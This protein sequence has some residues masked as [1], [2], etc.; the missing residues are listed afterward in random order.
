MEKGIYSAID[1]NINRALEGLRVCEDLFRFIKRNGKISERLKEIRHSIIEE[2]KI[3]P[4]ELLLHERDVEND[5]IKFT[6]LESET[7]RGSLY[8]LL[9]KNLHRAMEALRSIEEFYKLIHPGEKKNPFQGIR[10]SLYSLEK[11][12]CLP[13]LRFEKE[14][15]FE[16]SLYAILDSSFVEDNKYIETASRL[17]TG[18]ASIIQLRMKDSDLKE[19][20]SR[21]REVSS[22]CKEKNVLFIV[23]DYPEIAVLSDADGV[24]LGQDDLPVHEARKI[25]PPDMLIGVSTRSV[26]QATE[27][28]RDMPDYIAIGPVFDTKSK[29]GDLLEGIGINVVKEVIRKTD[30]PLVAIG[31]LNKENIPQLRE[32]G[33]SCFAVLSFLYKDDKIEENCIGIR[34]SI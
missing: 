20:L 2:S 11:E 9:R 26:S 17:I 1:A 7:K 3:F 29:N 32:I 22:F 19:I 28:D 15:F 8:D 18:G 12:I 23:N 25:L 6:D 34:D 21:A 5:E 30:V 13:L 10:F 31:G 27:A 14:K 24:H 33:C 16:N 4:G